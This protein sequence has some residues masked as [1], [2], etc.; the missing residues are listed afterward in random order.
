MTA[1]CWASRGRFATF[2]FLVFWCMNIEN[3]TE[4]QIELKSKPHQTPKTVPNRINHKFR[5]MVSGSVQ[6]LV[7]DIFLPPLP[8]DRCDND[9]NYISRLLVYFSQEQD[10]EE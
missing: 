2:R 6:F 8:I 9:E 5:C 10:D 1:A 7:F 4:H 3:H